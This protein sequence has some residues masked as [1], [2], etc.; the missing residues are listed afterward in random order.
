M[1]PALFVI[2]VVASVLTWRRYRVRGP[3]QPGFQ[4]SQPECARANRDGKNKSLIAA[5]VLNYE[6]IVAT[7][8]AQ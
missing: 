4:P 8:A 2:I 5:R 6:E 1:T 3:R 7:P